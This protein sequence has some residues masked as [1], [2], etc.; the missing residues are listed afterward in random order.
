VKIV[1]T[2]FSDE[3]YG[4]GLHKGDT[5]VCEAV[6]RAVTEMYQDGTAPSS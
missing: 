1:N 6:N 5:D 2:P 3:K 4:T